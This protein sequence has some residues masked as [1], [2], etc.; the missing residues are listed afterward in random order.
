MS[1]TESKL[2]EDLGAMRVPYHDTKHLF[3]EEHVK[4][5]PFVQFKTWFEDARAEPRIK[6]ANSFCLATCG[7]DGQ[8][9]ARMLLLKG[10]SDAGKIV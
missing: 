2:K 6:E 8:P 1:Q 9:S 7:A 3:L 4:S 5:D 10:F